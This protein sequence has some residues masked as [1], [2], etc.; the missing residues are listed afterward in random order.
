MVGQRNNPKAEE[1]ARELLRIWREN[2]LS[3]FHIKNCSSNLV[4]LLNENNIGN[5][6]KELVQPIK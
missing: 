1:N 4:S 2:K 5:N 6:F 3:V